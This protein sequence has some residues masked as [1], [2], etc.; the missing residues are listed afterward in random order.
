MQLSSN[1]RQSILNPIID[2]IGITPQ[3]IKDKV[4]NQI[5]AQLDRIV[6]EE[7]KHVLE[8]TTSRLETATN[9]SNT[10]LGKIEGRFGALE[11]SINGLVGKL[12]EG[13]NSLY[14]EIV[15]L[16]TEVGDLKVQINEIEI[17]TPIQ[18]INNL[19]PVVKEKKI[20]TIED[21]GNLGFGELIK[22]AKEYKVRIKPRSTKDVIAKMILKEMEN[23]A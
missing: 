2:A 12:S 21:L 6:I 10:S 7:V 17:S 23:A 9:S 14:T 3:Q 4:I 19:V 5:S 18:T 13:I 22:M 16:K 15:S 1:D 8:V 20:P 11:N